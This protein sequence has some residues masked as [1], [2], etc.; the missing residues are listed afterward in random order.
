M[1]NWA[2]NCG[3]DCEWITVG[4]GHIGS[5]YRRQR[6]LILGISR[7]LGGGDL[8]SKP[9]LAEQIRGAI[10]TKWIDRAPGS[11]QPGI[12]RGEFGV[13]SWLDRSTGKRYSYGVPSGDGTTRKRRQALGN[14]FDP[15]VAQLAIDRLLYHHFGSA[16]CKSQ[17]TGFNYQDSMD[18]S[19]AS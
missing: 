14:L 3:Y 13:T 18:I 9:T 11:F 5:P 7:S 15:R 4:S 19:R 1:L 8:R 10:K 16:Q 17:T 12:S 6:L 2:N